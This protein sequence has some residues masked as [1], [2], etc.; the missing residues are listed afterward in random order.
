MGTS[1]ANLVSY[2]RDDLRESTADEWTDAQLARYIS[3][4]EQWFARFLSSLRNSG[5]FLYEE[6]FTL[7]ASTETYD[8][9]G[10]TKGDGSAGLFTGIR[11]I[12]MLVG[13]NVWQPCLPIREGEEHFFRYPTTQPAQPWAVPGYYLRDALIVFLPTVSAART[14][15]INYSWVPVTKTTAGTAET[16]AEYDDILIKRAVYDALGTTGESE[17]TFVEKYA[18]RLAEV[19]SWECDR[20]NTGTSTTIKNVTSRNLFPMC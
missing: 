17:T 10:L 20:V 5:R 3:R 19:E 12:D 4:A 18:M 11:R 9:S 13:Q 14:L 1:Y 2:V 7:A 15:R 16:P 6:Q 8:T